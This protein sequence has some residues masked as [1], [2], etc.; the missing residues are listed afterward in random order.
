MTPVRTIVLAVA[1]LAG[2]ASVAMLARGMAS[3][4]VR[5]SAAAAAPHPT[6]Q[7]LV[8]KH[9]LAVGDRIDT[10]DVGW[11]AWPADATN[12]AYIVDGAPAAAP[13]QSLAGA[14]THLADAAKTAVTGP[15]AALTA[16]VGTLVR[17]PILAGEPVLTSKLVHAGAAGVMAVTLDPGDRAMAVPLSAESAVGGFILPGDHVDIVMSHQLDT[18][19]GGLPSATKQ[20]VAGVVLN[21]VRVLAIDQNNAGPQ[22]TAAEVGATATLEVSPEQAEQLVVAKATGQLT[23]VLRSYADAAGPATSGS[24]APSSLNGN[25]NVVRVFSP[26][27]SS[28]VMV[29]Q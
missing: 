19:A 16:V 6:V 7:V 28:S 29:T 8:A 4:Q 17:I 26:G 23:L 1:L 18:A 5:P 22:K 21:N 27:E 12:P 2:M 9:D 13:S 10:P 25:G 3:S 14:A 15:S 20:F 11:Q 24:G